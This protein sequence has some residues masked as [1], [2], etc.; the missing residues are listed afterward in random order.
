RPFQPLIS[1]PPTMPTEAIAIA[2]GTRSAISARRTAMPRPPMRAGDIGSG[3]GIARGGG[4]GIGLA[5]PEPRQ[6]L[7]DERQAG[8]AGEGQAQQ[9]RQP[10]DSERE[11]ERLRRIAGRMLA[12]G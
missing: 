11:A 3:A 10:I 2:I 8:E 6:G 1:A 9:Q 7:A 12:P 5:A 4:R